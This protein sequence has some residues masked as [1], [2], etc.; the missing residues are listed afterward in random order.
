MPERSAAVFVTCTKRKTCAP[1]PSM[2]LGRVAKGRPADVAAAWIRRL[3][4]EREGGMPARRLYSGDHWKIA[5]QLPHAARQ[6]EVAADLWVVSAGYGL[7]PCDAIVASYSATFSQ[8]HPDEIVRRFQPALADAKSAWWKELARW[9][10]PAV[11]SPRRIRDVARQCPRSPIL[12][13]ASPSYL[14]A[15]EADLLEAVESL[16]HPSLLVI[17]AAGA[18]KAGP[19]APYL[20]DCDSRFQSSLGGSRM[21]L[22]QR[23]ARHVLLNSPPWPWSAE[24]FSQT[25]RS[26]CVQQDHPPARNGKRLTDNEVKQYLRKKLSSDPRSRPTGLL[27]EL[28]SSGISCEQKRFKA[29]FNQVAEAHH[30]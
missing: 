1:A 3:E 10:G 26:T 2:C 14:E 17:V 21:S 28:R 18:R 22:N 20:V 15:I 29:L 16:Q 27:R 6:A 12:V 24:G 4:A 5:A 9:P 11:G 13:I 8:G 7:I 19:L 25:L 23:I 30:G